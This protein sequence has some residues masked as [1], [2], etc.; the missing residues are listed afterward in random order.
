MHLEIVEPHDDARFAILT[1]Y[2]HPFT[3]PETAMSV[4]SDVTAGASPAVLRQL[5]EGIKRDLVLSPRYG[6]ATDAASVFPRLTASIRPHAGAT[7]PAL[8]SEPWAIEA[9]SGMAWP[10]SDDRKKGPG[11]EGEAA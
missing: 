1:R 9:V 3:L 2:L 8:W 7:L 10:P 6:Q 11:T 5:M 4:L